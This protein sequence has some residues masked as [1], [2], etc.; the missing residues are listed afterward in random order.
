MLDGYPKPSNNPFH[1]ISKSHELLKTH[2]IPLVGE[3]WIDYIIRVLL[4]YWYIFDSI[5]AVL[6]LVKEG[7]VGLFKWQVKPPDG[8]FLC[9]PQSQA[10]PDHRKDKP[11]MMTSSLAQTAD[12]ARVWPSSPRR[13][14]RH[15]SS[16]L[17]FPTPQQTFNEKKR[18]KINAISHPKPKILSP[19][20][21]QS[22]RPSG[23]LQF[24]R[25]SSTYITNL[26]HISAHQTSNY[27]QLHRQEHMR[28]TRAFLKDQL[29]RPNAGEKQSA[30]AS[31]P[32][33]FGAKTLQV[34]HQRLRLVAFP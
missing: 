24:H 15:W 34:K 14:Q 2:R 30:R 5:C 8:M 32:W 6:W 1:V 9:K 17:P 10:T 20:Q 22:G 4:T 28:K 21:N 33:S 11:S 18:Q 3:W 26:N 16:C 27:I 7:S 25:D 12:K 29:P 13:I 23:F 19:S 31:S